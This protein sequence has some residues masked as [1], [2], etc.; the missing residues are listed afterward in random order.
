M[1]K[2]SICISTWKRVDDL[3]VLFESLLR[4]D[5][6]NL[7]VCIVDNASLDRTFNVVQDYRGIFA[8]RGIDC[9]YE[10]L[11]APNYNA[12]QTI[13]QALR[14]GTGDYLMIMDDDAYLYGNSVVSKLVKTMENNANVGIVGA[15]VKGLN[16]LSQLMI[17]NL[18]GS[19]IKDSDADKMGE[20]LYYNFHGA[21]ALFN[22]EFMISNGYYDETF[23]IY[24]NE[25][26]L[27]L[28]AIS[29]N[30]KVYINMDAIVIHKG[31]VN[32]NACNKKAIFAIR[33]YN[34]CIRRNFTGFLK[35]K[36]LILQTMMTFGYFAERILFWEEY[37]K[38]CIFPLIYRTI[39]YNF[40]DIFRHQK[41]NKSGYQGN[42]INYYIYNRIKN[43]FT[44]RILYVIKHKEGI[45]GFK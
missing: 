30:L 17:T 6:M 35:Y 32:M 4:Q 29:K 12:I 27:A 24:M 2:V 21:C 40:T 9:K 5:Y 8:N 26:D 23:V 20:I 33:N 34:R 19:V 36:C 28:K 7:E 38:R 11:P 22:K 25:L 13:N 41:K 44:D 39:L 43:S 16:G 42:L 45:R 18:D 3:K 1:K 15:N 37:K 14:M 10:L 31:T